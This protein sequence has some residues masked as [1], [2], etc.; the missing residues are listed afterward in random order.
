MLSRRAFEDELDAA[1]DAARDDGTVV[2]VLVGELLG[3]LRIASHF[4]PE[5]AVEAAVEA[6]CRVE[7]AVGADARAIGQLGEAEYAVLL[8][9]LTG[10]DEAEAVAARLRSA[11]DVDRPIRVRDE[12]MVVAMATGIATGPSRRR[13]DNELLWRALDEARQVRGSVLQRMLADARG[14]A[15]SLDEV[16][17]TFADQGRVMFSLDGCEFQLGDRR[18]RAP[19]TL[20]DAP[21]TGELPLRAE[22]RVIG[23]FRWWGPELDETLERGTQTLLDHVAAA[24][25][26]ASVLDATENRARTD[27]LTG[28]LNR[29]G[30]EHRR[31]E[32]RGT[33]AVGVIDL[34]HFKRINDEHGHAVGDRVLVGWAELL[35]RG[36]ADDLIARWG[37]EEIVIVMPATTVDGAVARLQRHLEEVQAF[38]R[39]GDVG[40]VT[41]SGGVTA[42]SD[43]E[44]FADAVRRAD[45]AMY[46]A[47]RAGRARIEAG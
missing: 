42:S 31:R 27:A 17:Q 39:V 36:R 43:L 18:W 20:P 16:A 6:R 28:L 22:G 24:L 33:Y 14:S 1:L 29:D 45:E 11:F 7:E 38:L 12:P 5:G 40:R 2:A 47:K 46:R 3:L 10:Q 34:D 26:R 41:F 30:L 25:D 4:G 13:S 8:T 44:A 9:G 19:A 21:P 15:S 32:L 23:S 35:G 37:G